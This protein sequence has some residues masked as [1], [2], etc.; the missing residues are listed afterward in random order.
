MRIL[1]LAYLTLA[2]VIFIEHRLIAYRW[3]HYELARRTMGIATVLGWALL[4]ALHGDIDLYSWIIVAV[5]FGIAGAMVGAL[6]TNEAARRRE[7]KLKFQRYLI[8][9]LDENQ[10]YPTR[11]LR[12]HDRR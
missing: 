10:Q 4:L 1:I 7:A 9:A 2:A 5:A 6:Y 11:I 3:R 8:E 12:E